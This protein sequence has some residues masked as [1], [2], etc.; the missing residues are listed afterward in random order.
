MPRKDGLGYTPGKPDRASGPSG[1]RPKVTSLAWQ[2]KGG[3]MALTEK[4]V[5]K[6]KP[7][8][9]RQHV[10]DDLTGFGVRVEPASKGG[11]KSYFFYAKIHGKIC[12]R[13]LGEPPSVPL[14]EA[15]AAAKTLIGIAAKWRADGFPEPS[16][17]AKKVKA[18]E[19]AVA[20]VFREL[21]EKY[22]IAHIWSTDEDE[23]ANHPQQAEQNARWMAKRFFSE[24]L[25]RRIDTIG[26]NDVAAVKN[27]CGTKIHSANRA[28][29][30]CSA[31]FNW[32]SKTHDGKVNFWKLE[33]NP[34]TGIECYKEKPRERF[35][36]PDELLRFNDALETEKHRDLSDF[37]TLSITTAARKGD[38]LGMK[39][40]DVSWDS[41]VWTVA[42]P[43]NGESYRVQLVETALA[44][45]KRRRSESPDS[46]IYVF[47]GVGRSGHLL[48]LR[49]AWVEFRK[50]AQI[51]DVRVHD[52][53]RTVGSYLAMSNVS[54]QRIGAVLG[55]KSTQ[56]TLVYARLHDKSVRDAREL[57]QAA[58][59]DAVNDAKQRQKL[60][61][62][63]LKALKAA[64]RG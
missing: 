43:K 60:A 42:F 58:M 18:P 40:S 19:P 44:V 7:G 1:Y 8:E 62:S 10:Y 4:V 25:D 14:A 41:A 61:A 39:W 9:K 50:R 5:E 17:F 37:L 28:I 54:L 13:S 20:P 45:L 46:A 53:R 16:P 3:C 55:H 35:L 52:L 33:Q 38:V 12:F 31:I 15:R 29:E 11:R 63:P 23:R 64:N 6:L 47:P 2:V 34:A 51:S 36:S 32:S 59:L 57:G 27:A 48:D 49:Q 22:I 56:S 24:W 21:L 26:V 30:F